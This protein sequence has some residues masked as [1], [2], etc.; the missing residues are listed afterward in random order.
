[1]HTHMQTPQN[2]LC[3][4]S[5]SCNAV[6]ARMKT[7]WCLQMNT[8]QY[9]QHCI[10]TYL[11]PDSQSTFTFASC[12]ATSSTQITK[13]QADTQ[14]YVLMPMKILPQ[15][16]YTVT[17]IHCY[18]N[19]LKHIYTYCMQEQKTTQAVHMY[20]HTHKRQE[21]LSSYSVYA[22]RRMSVTEQPASKQMF[23]CFWVAV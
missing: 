13:S 16:S 3:K 5:C 23:D 4:T 2:L 10:N 19:A 9:T 1:M 15:I 17:S 8:H 7:S 12:K 21:S 11:I 20:T 14:M 18:K 6:F 22:G